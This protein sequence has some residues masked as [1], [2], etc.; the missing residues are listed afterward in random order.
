MAVNLN[1]PRLKTALDRVN[2][3]RT[4]AGVAPAALHPAL[5]QSAQA[6]ADYFRQ[7]A[8][9]SNPHGE[10]TGK[11]GFTGP[12][13]N[14]RAKAAGYPNSDST[15]ENVTYIADPAVAVDSFIATIGHRATIIDPSYPDIGFGMATTPDGK[16]PIFVIDF[17]MP[18]WK[19]TFTP[20]WVQYPASNQTN[21][22]LQSWEEGPN[23]FAAFPAKFPIGNPVTVQYRGAGQITYNTN[24][25]SLTDM[26]GKPVAIYSLPTV[27][28]SFA[29]R[30]GAA[31]ATQQPLQPSTTYTATF[32]YDIA[33]HSTQLLTWHFSTGSTINMD[34]SLF[35]DAK[36]G[37]SDANVRKLWLVADGPVASHSAARTWI[38][39]PQAFDVRNEPYAQ[40]PGGQRTVYYFDK[41]RMEITNPN[42]DRNSQWF[43]TTGRLVAELI[44]GQMQ[45]GDSTFESKSPA[46]VAVAGD[47]ANI[48]PN[49][50]T[51]AS[52]ATVAS[53]NN[54]K[55]V[56]NRSGQNVVEAIDKNG[57]VTTLSVA[58]AA[59]K[60][61]YYDN[62][63]GHNVPDVIMTWA[64]T[65]PNPWVFVL[66][67]PL[68]E[69]YWT[70]VKVGSVEKDVLVQ[71]FERRTVTYTPTNDPVWRVEMGN[72]GQ[73]YH[74]WR[75]GN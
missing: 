20:A 10:D 32:G 74:L 59:V 6:H 39:G 30:N 3:Y 34:S 26:N 12:L 35:T 19:D 48:N 38:Y 58:P 15:N 24:L 1:D 18:V 28:H 49:A 5:V 56:A 29:M 44:S 50:P 27:P 4:Q 16:T 67:L 54:D 21:F 72:T 25:L 63:L 46:Q 14:D 13:W 73:H 69:P 51:Y 33:G 68:T 62:T 23:P 45:T 11:P 36:L 57:Q 66:G 7:N 64:A 65:L 42:G 9:L 75:Y 53:L 22:P 60:Y 17:G 52:F 37:N 31:F 70:K 8:P 2:L 41:A 47:P 71:I 55:R 43:V 61:S 40:S